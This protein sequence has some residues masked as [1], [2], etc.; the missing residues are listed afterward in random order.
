[1]IALSRQTKYVAMQQD[2]LHK[3]GILLP[4]NK[5]R[6]TNDYTKTLLHSTAQRNQTTIDEHKKEHVTSFPDTTNT[7][8]IHT[9]LQS[10]PTSTKQTYAAIEYN[11]TNHKIPTRITS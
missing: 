7:W 10:Y 1:M 4:C 9:P 2:L 11:R 8:F 6:F 3:G 5:K